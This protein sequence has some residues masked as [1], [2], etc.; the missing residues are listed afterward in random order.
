MLAE[1]KNTAY[2]PSLSSLDY[3]H[4]LCRYFHY[5]MVQPLPISGIEYNIH[6]LYSA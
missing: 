5:P 6:L 4:C 2:K 1:A 3:F